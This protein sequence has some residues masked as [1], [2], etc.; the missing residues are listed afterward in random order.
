[1]IIYWVLFCFFLLI[2]VLQFDT[3]KNR[4]NC[5]HPS[6]LL[7]SGVECSCKDMDSMDDFYD[8]EDNFADEFSD[9]EEVVFVS[10]F[11]TRRFYFFINEN[12]VLRINN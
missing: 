5:K 3:C 8:V 4:L 9:V 10:L 7:D 11:A 6:S 1:M 2:V 12:R